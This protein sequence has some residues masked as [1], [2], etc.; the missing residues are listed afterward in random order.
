MRLNFVLVANI[1]VS[2]LTRVVLINHIAIIGRE[3]NEFNVRIEHSNLIRFWEFACHSQ[4]LHVVNIDLS[5]FGVGGT[6]R[7]GH[8][9]FALVHLHFGNLAVFDV[10]LVFFL[11]KI[12]RR[13]KWVGVGFKDYY[14]M[15]EY[16][17][18]FW[19]F[20]TDNHIDG[21]FHEVVLITQCQ[22]SHFPDTEIT[23]I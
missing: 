4:I 22:R 8:P 15:L 10:L 9:V 6:H 19:I 5:R 20:L 17:D 11:V 1:N 21:I 18:Y 16:E 12:F 13:G 23:F 3:I 7:N 2:N 14:I